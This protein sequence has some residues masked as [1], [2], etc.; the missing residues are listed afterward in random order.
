MACT[1]NRFGPFKYKRLQKPMP[2]H[3]RYRNGKTKV[4]KLASKQS[5]KQT[6]TERNEHNN[7]LKNEIRGNGYRNEAL[8]SCTER[9]QTTR[10]LYGKAEICVLPSMHSSGKVA[11]VS[12]VIQ[13]SVEVVST[14]R[15][16]TASPPPPPPPPPHPSGTSSAEPV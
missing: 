12:S 7:Q 11:Q 5:S 9:F 10:S 14:V 4:N 2:K 16:D 8:T 1:S 13:D 6:N 3:V 15:L